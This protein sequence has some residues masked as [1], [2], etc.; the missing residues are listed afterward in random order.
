MLEYRLQDSVVEWENTEC[1]TQ[2]WN[3]KIQ[4]AGYDS[5]MWKYRMQDVVVEWGN[6]ECRIQ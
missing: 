3:G 1:R 5:G 2:Y 6:T 4:N